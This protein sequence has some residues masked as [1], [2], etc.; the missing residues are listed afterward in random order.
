MPM[1]SGANKNLISVQSRNKKKMTIDKMMK[2]GMAFVF[3]EWE[4]IIQVDRAM[5]TGESIENEQETNI[6]ISNTTVHQ[7][8]PNL[9]LN[10]LNSRLR[11]GWTITYLSAVSSISRDDLKSYE[12]GTGF[13]NA[14]VLDKLQKVLN[15]KLSP[16]I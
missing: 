16:L 14:D 13:P 9:K 1:V 7:L 11:K 6:Q 3:Q 4:P 15:V 5:S 12:L 10:I 8:A 2:P